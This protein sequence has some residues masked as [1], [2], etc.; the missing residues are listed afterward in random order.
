MEV[1]FYLMNLNIIFM[2]V[3]SE[4]RAY[5]FSASTVE[6]VDSDQDL[7]SFKELVV[8]TDVMCSFPA[9]GIVLALSPKM[10]KEELAPQLRIHRLVYS[11]WV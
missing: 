7:W 4:V 2:G 1:L 9:L 3:V 5:C 11:N 10:P 6:R 8:P